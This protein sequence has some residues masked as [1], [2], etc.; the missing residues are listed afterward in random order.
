[1]TLLCANGK[2]M[3]KS[4]ICCVPKKDT[5]QSINLPCV[6]FKP[7]VFVVAHGKIALCRVPNKK[8]TVNNK[9]H[10]KFRFSGSSGEASPKNDLGRSS[11]SKFSHSQSDAPKIAARLQAPAAAVHGIRWRGWRVSSWG[12]RTDWRTD[13]ERHLATTAMRR[14]ECLSGTAGRGWMVNCQSRQRRLVARRRSVG[15]GLGWTS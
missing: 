9:A 5:W 4:W 10:G 12:C 14:R 3:A 1:M 6:F 15:L 2:H 8:H 7:G 11:T 13:A